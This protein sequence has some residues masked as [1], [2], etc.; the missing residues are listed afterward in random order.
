MPVG[1]PPEIPIRNFSIACGWVLSGTRT[2]PR[3]QHGCGERSGGARHPMRVAPR[4]ALD[5]EQPK[6]V[7]TH[8]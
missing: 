5:A 8:I 6:R 4:K 2:V 1:I 3:Q 7:H